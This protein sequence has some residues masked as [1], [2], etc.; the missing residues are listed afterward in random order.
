MELPR[1]VYIGPKVN[2]GNTTLLASSP[3]NNFYITECSDFTLVTNADFTPFIPY[4]LPVDGFKATQA[5][6]W[7]Y[8]LH[9]SHGFRLAVT[10]DHL[11]ARVTGGQIIAYQYTECSIEG[12]NCIYYGFLPTSDNWS[13]RK[14]LNS[15]EVDAIDD[16]ENNYNGT[17]STCIVPAC[18]VWPR[19]LIVYLEREC[20]CDCSST[21]FRWCVRLRDSTFQHRVCGKKIPWSKVYIMMGDLEVNSHD[22][23]S[24]QFLRKPRVCAVCAQCVKC[25]NSPMFCRKHRICKHKSIN[26]FDQTTGAVSDI[27]SKDSIIALNNRLKIAK[28]KQCLKTN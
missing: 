28:M 22:T 8:I 18:K 1:C 24:H 19:R 27:D 15:S 17:H 10:R 5:E 23:L 25:S 16:S 6:N 13:G 11:R 26:V 3:S 21:C 7:R 9:I 14:K 4:S 12:N 20:A 2:L